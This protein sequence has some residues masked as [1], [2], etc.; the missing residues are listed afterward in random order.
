MAAGK[1]ELAGKLAEAPLH[2]IAHDGVADLL[3]YRI[4]NPLQR[5]AVIA[6]ANEK[7][8]AG[9]RRAPTGVRGEEIRAFPE[10]S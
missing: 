1:D 5:I 9:C 4:A 7:D 10:N 8:K 6:V 3:A 2:A